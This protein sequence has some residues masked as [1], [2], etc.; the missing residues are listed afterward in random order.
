MRRQP[1]LHLQPPL[2]LLE[3]LV[4]TLL[5]LF[6]GLIVNTVIISY[7]TTVVTAL[8]ARGSIGRERLQNIHNYLAFKRVPAHLSSRIL[9]FFQYKLTSSKSGLQET[10]TEELPP[11]LAMLLTFE[12]HRDLIKKCSIFMSLEADLLVP[13]LRRL[14]P[15]IFVP[16]HFVIR[17]GHTN[18]KLYFIHRGVVHVLKKSAE[19]H[20]ELQWVATM[21]NN[22]FFGENTFSSKFNQR[23]SSFVP[24]GSEGDDTPRASEGGDRIVYPSRPKR[25]NAS[26][27]CIS[28]CE[29][30]WLS[31]RALEAVSAKSD[32]NALSI[33]RD[34]L[35]EG[36]KERAHRLTQAARSSKSRIRSG[37][38]VAPMQRDAATASR[39]R[40]NWHKAGVALRF[41]Q[42]VPSALVRVSSVGR[43]ST[44]QGSGS[45]SST[46]K[47][48]DGVDA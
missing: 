37:A 24:E 42:A 17:E 43:M 32:S 28:Y 20:G 3:Q 46:T 2:T 7:T 44:G 31:R 29:M 5:T 21:T 48:S 30:L 9:E 6:S 4:V 11:E 35:N 13:I 34:A 38:T 33:I 25:A 39:T 45:S 14:R 23:V 16:G 47:T 36:V 41:A 8:D 27:Q 15:A 26:V 18:T 19:S 40:N 1:A 12:L 22:D 10:Y